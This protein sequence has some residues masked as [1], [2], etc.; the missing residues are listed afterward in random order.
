MTIDGFVKQLCEHC[1][2]DPEVLD[3]Q[4]E[5]QEDMVVVTLNLPEEDSGRF[6]GFH[7]E[8]LES[9]QRVVRIIF[10]TEYPDKKVLLNINN[11]RQEREIKLKEL[12]ETAAARVLQ[13][14]QPYRFQSYLPAHERFIIHSTL[15]ELPDSEKLESVSEGDGKDRRLSIRLKSE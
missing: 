6:I 3:V 15:S 4:L 7:G 14:G 13:S 12:A 11:Y 9:I 5:D 1:G 2:V 10:S 8:T